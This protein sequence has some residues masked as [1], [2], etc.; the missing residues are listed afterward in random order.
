MATEEILMAAVR[1]GGDR[2]VFHEQLRKH[3]QAAAEQVKVHGKPNDLVARL[4]A[5]P[6][7]AKVNLDAALDAKTFVGRAP[8]QTE[9]FVREMIDPIR[10]QYAQAIK[11][12]VELRV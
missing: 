1:A 5:D 11:Q 12:K 4:K 9:A 7:F 3:S 8:Q 6:A 2:Q 10:K